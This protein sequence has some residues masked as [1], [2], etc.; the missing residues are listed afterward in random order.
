[1][2]VLR[3]L[4][5][6]ALERAEIVAISELD[7]ERFE[8]RPVAVTRSGAE[9]AL[10]VALEVVLNAIVVQQRVVHVDEEDDGSGGQGAAAIAASVR[11]VARVRSFNDRKAAADS[12]SSA[13]RQRQL[14]SALPGWFIRASLPRLRTSCSGAI[15]SA[16]TDDHAR[17]SSA[18][19]AS[20]S[21]A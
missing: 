8:D 7:E 12:N 14:P 18:G 1:V 11:A 21:A 2:H 20:S 9:L 10:E 13:T 5:P 16:A 4:G 17:P 3:V 6:V 19:A 15:A